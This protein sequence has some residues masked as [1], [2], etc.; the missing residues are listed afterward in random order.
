MA[1]KNDNPFSKTDN[2]AF[3]KMASLIIRQSDN[4]S[5]LRPPENDQFFGTII[6]NG[7]DNFQND[8]DN[9]SSNHVVLIFEVLIE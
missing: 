7:D 6:S 4:P 2:N 9:S 3:S 5:A 8:D 1:D